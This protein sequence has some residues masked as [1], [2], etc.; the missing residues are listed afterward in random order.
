MNHFKPAKC[1]PTWWLF[2]DW[3]MAK[4]CVS[5]SITVWIYSQSQCSGLVFF[6]SFDKSEG[7]LIRCSLVRAI[8]VNFLVTRFRLYIHIWFLVLVLGAGSWIMLFYFT[9]SQLNFFYL[10]Y[11]TLLPISLLTI[12]IFVITFNI[13]CEKHYSF[14]IFSNG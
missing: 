13:K 6:F 3:C 11:L 14:L 12:I 9:F 1:A 5:I 2:L 7:S 4:N 10:S 8:D